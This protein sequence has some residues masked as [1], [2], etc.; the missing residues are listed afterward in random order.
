MTQQPE[1]TSTVAATSTD[2]QL[3]PGPARL[4]ALGAAA[5]ALVIY[6]LGFFDTDSFV[7]TSPT[8][9]FII[10][11]GLLVGAAVLPKVGRVLLPGVVLILVGTLQFLQALTGSTSSEF[12]GGPGAIFVVSLV[13]SFLVLGLAL[14]AL[15]LHLGIVKVPAPRPSTP[16]GYGGYSGYGQQPGYGRPGYGQRPGYGSGYVPPPGQS[17]YGGPPAGGHGQQPGFGQAAGYGAAPGYAGGYATAHP[18]D[19]AGS[20]DVTASMA[21]PA[22]GSVDAQPDPGGRH[23]GGA[24]R[25][26]SSSASTPPTGVPVTPDRPTSAERPADADDDT[27]FITPGDPSAK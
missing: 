7:T 25:D 23:G 2:A 26:V 5:L 15:L 12:G 1:S 21:T 24:D 16:P 18:G 22:A 20:S 3:A 6:V 10:G 8:G 13:L 27:R 17:G 9:A 4:L 11:G 14:G 19:P